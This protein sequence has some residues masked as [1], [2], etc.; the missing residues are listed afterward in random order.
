MKNYA[1][2]F[3]TESEREF[4]SLPGDVQWRIKKKMEFFVRAENPLAYAK[5]LHGTDDKYRFRIGDYRV[6]VAPKNRTTIIVILL[7]LKIG[8]RREVY[9]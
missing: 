8:H 9:E 6:I 3:T 7:I 5:K 2:E 4:L 1:L